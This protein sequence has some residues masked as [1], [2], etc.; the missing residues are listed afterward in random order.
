[1]AAVDDR[2]E[3]CEGCGRY[4]LVDELTTVTM[5]N[6]EPVACCPTCAPHAR[7]AARKQT[8]LDQRR[9]TCDGCTRELLADDLE[10][11]VLP[12]G[13]VV[14]CCESCR[15]EVPG[16]DGGPV[17]EYDGVDPS[18][19]ADEPEATNLC[20][21]CNEWTAAERF[22]VTTIDDRTEKLCPPCKERAE[23]NG[24]I[25]DVE[26]RET[27]AREILDVDED[28]PAEEIREAFLVQIKHAHPDRKGGSRSAFKLVKEAYDRLS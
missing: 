3:G 7:E 20:T 6:G 1:M 28:A 21:Q 14:S 9:D 4:V 22:V 10:D 18:A 15:H 12:D 24:V 27:R 5:P 26:L 17:G 16:K 23:E 2:R 25:K 19:R 13:T 11:V 8:S